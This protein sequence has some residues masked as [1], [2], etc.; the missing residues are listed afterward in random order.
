ML[1]SLVL[2]S[3]AMVVC[4]CEG[5]SHPRSELDQRMFGPASVRIHPTFT[6]FR[7]MGGAGKPDGIE[8][9]LEVEDPFGEPTRSTGRA[10]FELY[11]YVKNSPRIRGERLAGPWIAPLDTRAEQ[12]EHWNPALRAYTFELHYPK[13]DPN[14]YYV[15]TVQFDLNNAGATSQPTTRSAMDRPGRLF[16]QLIIAPQNEANVHGKKYH[17]PPGSPNH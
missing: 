7:D 2:L 16:D 1:R 11:E 6:Q 5:T 17:A 3:L 8:A 14:R 10:M 13:I 4:G 15:L 9:T 12:Q